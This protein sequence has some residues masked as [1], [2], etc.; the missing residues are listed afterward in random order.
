MPYGEYLHLQL[1]TRMVEPERFKDRRLVLVMLGQRDIDHTLDIRDPN[2]GIGGLMGTLTMHGAKS[3]YL[4]VLPASVVWGLVPA[5]E[6]GRIKVVRMTGEP[7]QHGS[8][9]IG[10]ISFDRVFGEE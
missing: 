7:I 1:T 10:R 6:A 3:K 5:L 2:A 4:G 9:S 8:A